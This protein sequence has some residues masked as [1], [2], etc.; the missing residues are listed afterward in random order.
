MYSST[1]PPTASSAATPTTAY[2]RRRSSLGAEPERAP[3]R[4]RQHRHD[5][6]PETLEDALGARLTVEDR[7]RQHRIDDDHRCERQGERVHEL[8]SKRQ[9]ARPDAHREESDHEEDLLPR[10][11]R[12]EREPAH[13]RLVQRRHDDV[14]HARPK[15]K[16]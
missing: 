2:P 1:I 12:I 4:V 8:R 10:R 16:R 6:V 7:L 14:V 3:E 13:A 5:R 9:A 11:D 15:T